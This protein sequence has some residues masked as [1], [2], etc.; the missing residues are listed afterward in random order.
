[1]IKSS[2]ISAMRS[3]KEAALITLKGRKPITQRN[4]RDKKA[5][6]LAIR[7]FIRLPIGAKIVSASPRNDTNKN[8]LKIKKIAENAAKDTA[9]N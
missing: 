6:P 9:K 3:A 8:S 4:W 7:F 5:A 2:K 1:M